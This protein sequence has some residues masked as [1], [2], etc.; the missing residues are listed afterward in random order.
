MSVS[1]LHIEAGIRYFL[2][3][4]NEELSPGEKFVLILTARLLDEHQVISKQ[5]ICEVNQ[6]KPA[7]T[8]GFL[9]SLE[10]KGYIR[11]NRSNQYYSR[12]FIT[13]T[14]KGLNFKVRLIRF[15]KSGK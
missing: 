14:D 2:T 5:E 1:L 10:N 3:E 7:T 15:I 4:G 6:A 9:K 11:S 13:F 12:S 8:Y